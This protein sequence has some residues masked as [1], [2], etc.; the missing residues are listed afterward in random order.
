MLSRIM[1]F[2]T[3]EPRM[4]PRCPQGAPKGRTSHPDSVFSVDFD[5]IFDARIDE[6]SRQFK[7]TKKLTSGKDFNGNRARPRMADLEDIVEKP[8]LFVQFSIFAHRLP[9]EQFQVCVFKMSSK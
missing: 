1:N 6:F 8:L 2:G 4:F 5:G 7:I 9:R 3:L